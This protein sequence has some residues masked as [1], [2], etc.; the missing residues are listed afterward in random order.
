MEKP[1][2]FST[3]MVQAILNLLKTKT[4]RLNG[5]KEINENPDQW[6]LDNFEVDPELTAHDKDGEAYPKVMKGLIATFSSNVHGEYF[7]NIKCPWEVGDILWV[8]ETWQEVYNPEHEAKRTPITDLISNWDDIPKTQFPDNTGWNTKAFYVYKASDIQYATDDFLHWRPSIFM[9]RAAA[10]LFLKVMNIRIERLQDITEED[11]RAEGVKSYWA[12]PHR[13]VAPFIGRAK[14]IG[15][16]LCLTRR[17]A[18]QQLW[19]SLNAKRGYAFELNPWC[20]VIE[21]ERVE[22]KT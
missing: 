4:R 21:F 17:E 22:D 20:W 15:E 2:L 12:E 7:R 13:D 8:R 3:P 6:D 14:G 11:A 18:F 1:I 5:L 16:D 9:P 19:D 10:R